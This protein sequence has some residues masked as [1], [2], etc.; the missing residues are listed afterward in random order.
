MSFSQ[1]GS[2]V[3]ANYTWD[4]GR[5]EGSLSGLVFSGKWLEA[6][7]YAE[8]DDAG[9]IEFSF[10]AD[11]RSF[12]GRWRYGSSGSWSGDWSGTSTTATPIVT[13][14]PT[15]TPAPTAVPPTAT[16]SP[17]PTSAAPTA[18]AA[19]EATPTAEPTA[20][21]EGD[22]SEPIDPFV[23]I[24]GIFAAEAGRDG[25]S[26]RIDELTDCPE[27]IIVPGLEPMAPAAMDCPGKRA[28][29]EVS[30]RFELEFADRIPD[31]SLNEQAMSDHL[32]RATYMAGMVGPGGEPLFP[33]VITTIPLIQKLA[34]LSRD[35]D[36]PDLGADGYEDLEAEALSD[37]K[38][39]IELLATNDALRWEDR[40]P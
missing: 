8:P 39:M 14:T 1:S 24:P 15:A 2:S 12:T 28:G 26:P 31:A 35:P 21:D 37:V 16:P 38:R 30:R 18:T 17:S 33:S 9:D 3:T 25:L 20:V 36:A 22:A 6:P 5:V 23:A 11:C 19:E 40:F 34:D 27:S 4:E 10:S 32:S 29:W 13:S 7:S